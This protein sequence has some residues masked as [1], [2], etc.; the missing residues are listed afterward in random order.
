MADF[1]PIV[2]VV[3]PIRN[4]AR[5]IERCLK[6]VLTQDYPRERLEILVVDGMSEDNTR[7]IVKQLFAARINQKSESDGLYRINQKLLDNPERIVPTALNRGIRAARGAVIVRIDGHTI[8]EPD[9]VSRCV[10]ALQETNADNVGGPM[11]AVS[12]TYIGNVIALATSS[13]FGV[14]G[15]R[16]HY[17]ETAQWV[18]TVYM[19][20]YPRAVFDRIGLFDEELVRNQD[21]E[22]NF[23]LTQVGGK[24]W[25]DPQIKSI[26]FSR[27]TLRGL[28]KQYYEYGF[29]KVRVIQKHGRPASLRHLVPA[30]FVLA[31]AGSAL[32]SI[33]T[34]T[35]LWF[36]LIAVPYALAALAASVIAARGTWRALV[37][38]PI[39][40][41]TL[42]LSY[43]IGFLV[44][45]ARWNLASPARQ[46]SPQL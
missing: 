16:F 44:G 38:L 37:L 1:Y 3:I 21:D 32:L 9:Y 24:I 46:S 7:E 17:A 12:E 2:S 14:G 6:A 19:G 30:L 29:W 20:A 41:L 34:Q 33:V 11:R 28:W 15:A 31:L 4:E 25:L 36:L 27:G 10:R 26:Y 23:R 40:F 35:P 43:G 5:Y 45:L 22:F 13:P 39:V 42:H 8:I 18:D